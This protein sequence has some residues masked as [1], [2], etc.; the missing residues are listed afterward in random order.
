[1]MKRR[2]GFRA[3]GGRWLLF[4]CSICSGVQASEIDI[5]PLMYRA[6]VADSMSAT[7]ASLLSALGDKNYTVVNELNVQ[8]GLKN[9]G[10]EAEP[11]LLIEFINL[12]KAYNITKS[13]RGFELFAPLR[14]ALFEDAGQRTT[15]MIM[16]PSFIKKTL[17]ED[18][19]SPEGAAALDDF[20]QD[21]HNMLD[22]LAAGG[23]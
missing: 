7:R 15:I 8:L 13:N 17:A 4:L 1:M 20:E 10:I 5:T 21:M 12:S 2:R 14:A 22:N 11:I 23:F 3:H 9:R 16:R 18:G 19:L 6:V